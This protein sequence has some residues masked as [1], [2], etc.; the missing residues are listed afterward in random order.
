V[1]PARFQ[2]LRYLKGHG[3]GLVPVKTNELQ[4]TPGAWS[5]L[6][7]VSS[8]EQHFGA[9]ATWRI[10]GRTPHGSASQ[11]VVPD[12]FCGGT[13]PRHFG[14]GLQGID[15]S[16]VFA[17]SPAGKAWHARLLRGRDSLRCVRVRLGHSPP[18]T[19]CKRLNGAAELLIA[20]HH[21]E[22]PGKKSTAVAVAARGLDEVDVSWP[23]G[24]K[25]KGANGAGQLALASLPG[26]VDPDSL[27]IVAHFRDG[28]QRTIDKAARRVLAEDP[29]GGE[30]W[31]AVA[32][33]GAHRA[34]GLACTRWGPVSS[35]T[36][37]AV[38]GE[39]GNL[40]NHRFFF[41]FRRALQYEDAVGSVPRAK[42]VFGAAGPQVTEVSVS[43][44]D[45]TRSLDLAKRGRAFITVYGPEVNAGDLTITLKLESGSTKVYDGKR[46]VH[47]R[48][49]K[50]PAL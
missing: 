37:G 5:D 24:T 11:G 19:E 29:E 49:P 17:P 36:F 25:T 41:A 38:Y 12:G 47:V 31:E 48:T 35:F 42:A 44:P 15:R 30:P 43:G 21:F 16:L 9:G 23:G 28:G 40:E 22:R 4:V 1:S 50:R 14:A 33:S 26:L 8:A 7:G 46:E 10:Y 18:G 6:I 2:V 32:E 45:G 13:H 39:C 34:P 27:K 3:P 20:I